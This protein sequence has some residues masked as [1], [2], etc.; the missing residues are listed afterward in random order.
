[1]GRQRIFEVAAVF[2]AGLARSAPV[3]IT[4]LLNNNLIA[5]GGFEENDNSH[6]DKWF[7]GDIPWGRMTVSTGAP[8][9]GRQ[10]MEIK[11]LNSGSQSSI[12]QYSHYGVPESYLKTTP[13]TL[14]SFGG[15]MR[16]PGIS[17]ASEHWFEWDS[18]RTGEEPGPRP[19]LPWPNYFTPPLRL[20]AGAASGWKYLNRV[21]EMPAGFPNAQLRHRF[22]VQGRG[23]GSVF[24]DNVFFRP[25]PGVND[26]SWQVAIPFGATWQWTA[27]APADGSWS[28]GGPVNWPSAPAKF[29]AGSGPQGIRTA[30]PGRRAAYYFRRSFSL[31]TTN[32][33]E[34]LMSATCTDDY[35]GTVHP[36]RLFLNGQ[37]LETGPVEAVSGEGNVVKH[38]DLAAFREQFRQ[39]TNWLGVILQNAWAA[40][41]DNVAFDV[42]MKV[43][44]NPPGA[45]RFV[46]V[47]RLVDGTVR[48]GVEGTGGSRWR[49]ESSD[50]LKTW[51]LV[52]EMVLGNDANTV[53]DHGQNGRPHPAGVPARYYRLRS[54]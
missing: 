11:L 10:A 9:F 30:V 36:M 46:E 42:A 26:P 41:W 47:V 12:T 8:G 15:H 51:S 37:E 18:A 19:G 54:P 23:T 22:T 4:G 50:D 43:V 32:L 40:D 29:G 14:Y 33:A 45:P 3:A 49:L 31:A 5:N 53:A 6:W 17:A 25:L 34:I 24:L 48:I 2:G 44:A 20:A 38:Y 52:E 27:D 16:S 35:G 28:A 7:T 1:M 21:F 39:G 13:G